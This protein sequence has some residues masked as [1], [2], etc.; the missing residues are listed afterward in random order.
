MAAK[1]QSSNFRL[2][3]PL[4]AS[5]IKGFKPDRAVK[6][7]AFDAKGHAY[8]DVVKLDA[9]GKGI[10]SLVFEELPGSVRV[11]VGPENASAE[12]MKGLQTIN[13]VVA[14]RQWRDKKELT[15]AA[16]PISAYYWWWW[17]W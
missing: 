8:E 2:Q 15:I 12:Q 9:K 16:V 13:V 10:A 11:A 14:S 6:V 17:L 3:I 1:G 4:D 5:G 7:V